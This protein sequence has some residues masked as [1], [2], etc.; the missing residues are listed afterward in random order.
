MVPRPV[1]SGTHLAVLSSPLAPAPCHWLPR[2]ASALDRRSAPRL[3]RLAPGTYK[4]RLPGGE[5]WA[6]GTT[7]AEVFDDHEE[8]HEFLSPGGPF[9]EAP[10]PERMLA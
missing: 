2:L 6:R 9:F 3:A 1:A 4:L 8:S 7:D 5:A 10:T